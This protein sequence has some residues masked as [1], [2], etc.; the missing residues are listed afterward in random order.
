MSYPEY[1]PYPLGLPS[2]SF[3]SK[4]T[5]L[6]IELDHLRKKEI[7]TAIHPLLFKQL[8]ELFHI[9]EGLASARIE[10]NNTQLLE[11]LE[12]ESGLGA[13][14]SEEVR[15]IRNLE[16]TLAYIDSV[17]GRRDIDLSFVFEIHQRIMEGLKPP[18]A[19]D[20]DSEAGKFRQVEVGIAKSSHLPPPPWE[21]RGLMD[22]L[23]EFL[24]KAYPPKYDLIISA[25][26]HHRFVWIHPFTNG[27]GRTVRMLTYALL[28]KQGFKVNTKR[29]LNP[30]SAFCLDRDQYY[31]SL[32]KADRGDHDGILEWCFYMLNSLR[33]EF[34]KIDHLSDMT[35]L[36]TKILLP[37]I[38]FSYQKKFLTEV[39]WRILKMVAEKQLVQAD[40][41]KDIFKNKLPQEISR[42][43]RR[44]RQLNL[45]I[46]EKPNAR[47]YVLNIRSDL[48]RMGL[49]YVFDKEG[50]LP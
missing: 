29:I 2:P 5:D 36:K 41:F 37:S 28:I 23:L 34:E 14:V 43:I 31:K 46:P 4:I 35:F 6:I 27:N 8:V 20:G 18:P 38:D 50:F 9:V 11:L 47:K 21:I 30:A 45:L 25:I 44:L 19:G 15:E 17:I 22:E 24:G 33:K 48:L 3:D 1:R 13:N 42:Q 12:L 16:N 40:D 10:G 26:V 49:L 7:R 32:A 39:E